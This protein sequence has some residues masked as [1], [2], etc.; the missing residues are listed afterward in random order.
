MRNHPRCRLIAGRSCATASRP[1]RRE[2]AKVFPAV[3]AF[4]RNR[5]D[6][7]DANR[8]SRA[9]RCLT[10]PGHDFR[11]SNT[12]KPAK[13]NIDHHPIVGSCTR[14]DRRSRISARSIW[15]V[16][17]RVGE[18]NYAWQIKKRTC[19]SRLLL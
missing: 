13:P 15:N 18:R 17:S 9:L 5:P 16:R 11:W 19:T 3:F 6:G 10:S 2:D 12:D 8:L 14:K 1:P 7:D 4:H